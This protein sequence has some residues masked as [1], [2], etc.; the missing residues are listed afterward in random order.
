[1]FQD[2][3]SKEI[4]LVTIAV[5][6]LRHL[7]LNTNI[8][9]SVVKS[10]VI[11]AIARRISSASNDFL[12]QVAGLFANLSEDRDAQITMVENDVTRAIIALSRVENN[13][14]QRVSESITYFCSFI[15]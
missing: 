7:T 6:G 4:E 14:V 8:N 1:M 3:K 11:T 13:E 9:T 10:G 12:C 2:L 15:T 5:A